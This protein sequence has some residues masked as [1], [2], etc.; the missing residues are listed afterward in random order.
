M[1]SVISLWKNIRGKTPNTASVRTI[2][3]MFPMFFGA[4]VVLFASI[5]GSDKSYVKLVPSQTLVM[6]GE[7][8]SVDVYV[9]AHIPVNAIDVRVAFP[10]DKVQV[11]G[12]DKGGSVLT[13][14]TEEPIIENNTVKF[15]GGT[16]K[17]GFLGEHLI[18]TINAKAKYTGKT[19]FAVTEAQLLA[20]DGAGSVV[21]IDNES[22]ESK[23]S[24]YIYDQNEDPTKISAEIGV[25]IVGDLDG[26]GSVSIKDISVFMANWRSKK[27]VYDFN[28][29]GKMNFIDFSIILARSFFN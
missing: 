7:N 4:I 5:I 14:W 18:G 16:F 28:S 11:L 19:E 22:T 17:R 29:D 23:T 24:F 25:N 2:K 9:N 15:S 10:K 3:Y 8:F 13:I 12:I 1:K 26:D 27:M 21:A 20:G 6:Q